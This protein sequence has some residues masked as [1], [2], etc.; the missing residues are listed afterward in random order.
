MSS[1]VESTQLATFNP[2]NLPHS[3]TQLAALNPQN[4][5]RDSLATEL[6]H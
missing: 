4:L 5:L 6:R 2:H 1:R 3:I